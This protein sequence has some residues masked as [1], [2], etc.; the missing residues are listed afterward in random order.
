MMTGMSLMTQLFGYVICGL[1]ALLG[2]TLIVYIWLGRIDISQLISEANGEASFSRFQLLVFTFV[3]AGSFSGLMLMR[4][5][6]GG[7]PDIPRGVL[8]LLGISAGTY[9]IS[10]GISYSQSDVVPRSSADESPATNGLQVRFHIRLLGWVPVA[11][12]LAMVVFL[13][14]AVHY[15]E[16]SASMAALVIFTG[17]L[18]AWFLVLFLQAVD[19]DGPPQFETN[20]GGLGGGLGGWRFSASLIYLICSFVTGAIV[21]VVFLHR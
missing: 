19:T 7:V 13:G 12:I 5:N 8:I 11:L 16:V 20:W 15:H 1:F 2:I 18:A 21:F 4:G 17:G 10:K 6:L 14:L 3:I 9:L